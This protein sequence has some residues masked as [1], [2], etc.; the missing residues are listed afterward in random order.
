M[1]DA[2]AKLRAA[3]EHLRATLDALDGMPAAQAPLRAQL[4]ELEA[5]LTHDT[6]P[7]SP[8]E[9]H[10]TVA[11]DVYG[12]VLS[13]SFYAPVHLETVIYGPDSSAEQRELLATYLEQLA[14]KLRR[15]PLRGL[16]PSLDNGPGIGLPQVYVTLATTSRTVIVVGGESVGA[17]RFLTNGYPSPLKKEYA[18]DWALPSQAIIAIEPL[19]IDNGD[20]EAPG[21]AWM[22]STLVAEAVQQ[23][24]RLVLLGDPGSGKSTVLR[25][26]AWSMAMRG[27][28]PLPGWE[29]TPQPL[30]LLL[31]LRVL[32]AQIARTGEQ[33]ATLSAAL[34]EELTREYDLAE[35][36]ELVEQALAS[37]VTLLLLDGLDEVPLEANAHISADRSATLQTIRAFA[38]LHGGVRIVITCRSRAFTG[39]FQQLLGW[40]IETIAPLTL[41]QIRHF[42]GEWYTELAQ[43]GAIVQSL[44]VRQAAAL[45]D[46][47][48]ANRR[49]RPMAENPLLLTMMALVLGEQGELPRDRALLYEQILDQLLGKWDRQRG[50]PG[51][52]E[53]IGQVNL[54]VSDLRPVIDQLSFEAHKG[55]TMPDR[56]G[57]LARDTVQL[58][59]AR[60]FEQI[61]VAGAW[62][63]AGRCLAYI[64]ERSGLLVPEDDGRSYTF[65]HLTLQEHGAG[66]HMLL[67]PDAVRLVMEHRSQDM[68]HEPVALGL[69]VLHR[70]FPPLADRIDRILTELI[71]PDEQGMPKEPKRWYCDLVLAAEFGAE[72]DW[73]LLRPLIAV[74]RLRRDLRRGLVILLKDQR[75]QLPVGERVRA[76]QFLGE[77]G[78]P[79]FPVTPEQWRDAILQAQAG[80]EDGYFCQIE[81]IQPG[82]ARW[83]GRFPITNA[84]LRE[85]GA[86]TGVALPRKI[87]EP[88]YDGANQPASGVGWNEAVAF[89]GWVSR[90]VGATIRLP[91]GAEWEAAA[92]A[93]DGRRYPWGQRRLSDRA[94]IKEDHEQ[95]GGEYPVP[96]G[97]YPAG[98]APNGALD[99]LGNVWEWTLD[100]LPPR[101]SAEEQHQ[102]YALRGGAYMTKK[103]M[104]ANQFQIGRLPN[105]PLDNG[106]RIVL[107]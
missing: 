45:V 5:R 53:A 98:A 70:R 51:L 2:R 6:Q 96:V 102:R 35:P 50:G 14:A 80:V 22:R 97:C 16:A 23:A 78:D 60:F 95:R 64:D 43:R 47:I 19:S 27:A 71:D 52:A 55:I 89:C 10:I 28:A 29:S 37:D 17:A 84:Q 30:P 63:A 66:R 99:L 49:L 79:R 75:Q 88:H 77:L 68:W 65:A 103:R 12:P 25:H 21:F 100:R 90:E 87:S 61:R 82:M 85:W 106:F 13:G 38:E 24:P 32:A 94:A 57:R 42:A 48:I 91:G 36:G 34:C 59:L 46:A 72:R 20:D 86:A 1:S 39:E 3:I 26:L 40:P 4:A 11:R 18:P 8:N 107:E 41:G 69:G 81:P 92:G 83:I 31:P 15:L 58:A 73:N 33:P 44:G 93:H 105:S 74:D 76:A 104:L 62:E 54:S 7:P 67:Q 101:T 9:Q 56:R